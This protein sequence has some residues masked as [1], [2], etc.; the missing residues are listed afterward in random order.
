MGSI[1]DNNFHGTQAEK[2]FID[3]LGIWKFIGEKRR[4]RREIT[5]KEKVELLVG[6]KIGLR[7]RSKWGAIEKEEIIEHLDQKI[8]ELGVGLF[9]NKECLIAHTISEEKHIIYQNEE[10]NP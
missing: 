6:Y 9:L 4:Y 3:N 5:N 10:N 2:H 1:T 7:K 8:A